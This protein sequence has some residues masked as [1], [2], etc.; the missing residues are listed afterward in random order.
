MA[1]AFGGGSYALG[2][3]ATRRVGLLQRNAPIGEALGVGL[4]AGLLIFASLWATV[5]SIG[6]SS[7][8]PIAVAIAIALVLM[9]RES[10]SGDVDHARVG[11]T[12]RFPRPIAAILAAGFI[13]GVG[14]TYGSTMAQS[15]IDGAQPVEHRDEAFYSVLA[16]DLNL[17]GVESITY[18]SG[19]DSIEGLA[20]QNWF[21]WGEMWLSAAV[22][23]ISGLDPVLARHYVVLPLLLLAAAALTG[24]LVRRL[25]R[26]SSRTA[27]LF[28]AAAS[29]LLAPVPFLA[30]AVSGW[31]PVGLLYGIT[32]YGLAVIPALLILHA[33]SID[34]SRRPPPAL[35][36]FRGAVAASLLPTHVVVAVLAIVG[37]GGVFFVGAIARLVRRRG[38]VI[39]LGHWRGTIAAVVG[40]SLATV[41]WGFLTDHSLGAVGSST[42]VEPF[43]RVWVD[44]V[45]GPALAAGAFLAIPVAW[46]I[47]RDG[48]PKQAAVFLGTTVLVVAGAIA[49]GADIADFDTFHIFFAGIAVFATPVAAV[50]VWVIVERFRRTGRPRLATMLIVL[51]LI[52]LEIGILP[53]VARLQQFGPGRG[54]RPIPLDILAVIRNLPPDAKLAYACR[55]DE[56]EAFWNPALVSV[57]AHTDHRVVPI[58][59]EVDVFGGLI[60]ANPSGREENPFF[61]WAPQRNLYPDETTTPGPERIAAFLRANHI[62]YIYSDMNHPNTLIPGA[63]RFASRNDVALYRTR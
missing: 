55:P 12:D 51:S 34:H 45:V 1:L 33:V 46:F 58:C 8:T 15:P 42:I 18:P 43:N 35:A 23:R 6:R 25:A 13:V 11:S 41:I 37:A 47:S 7:F 38:P 36:L 3:W 59:Y 57:T 14:L 40:I 39:G 50:A 17:N 5:G 48:S 26:T 63:V 32:Q 16:A 29:M 21:H 22:I 2:T 31:W 56:E 4:G 54:Y 53:A 27:F 9:R 24:T 62:G 49:W 60:G 20:S 52:Q 19:F 30:G 61:R 28:G 44:A 10:I